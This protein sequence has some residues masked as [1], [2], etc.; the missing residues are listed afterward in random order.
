[1]DISV[2]I[3]VYNEKESVAQL[4]A[5]IQAALNRFGKSYEIIFI[6]DGSTDGTFD[7][8]KN[9]SPIKIIRFRRNF[10][11]TAALDA[12]FK[13]ATGEIVISIGRGSPWWPRAQTG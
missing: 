8:L 9:L 4:H 2:I 12:G 6:D 1:M 13:A 10:G 5:E 3:P 7:V 11:Q